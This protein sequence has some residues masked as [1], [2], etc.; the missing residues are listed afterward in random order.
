MFFR[1]SAP[2]P[3]T[4]SKRALWLLPRWAMR[5][6]GA[7]LVWAITFDPGAAKALEKVS[8]QLKWLHQFQFAGYYVAL[9]QGYYRDAGLD[10][11]IRQGGPFIDAMVDVGS[12]KADFGVCASGVVLPQAAKNKV[13]VL[14]VIFQHSAANILVPSR[15]RINAL[16]EL[17]GHRLMDASGSEDLAAMLKQQG[18]DYAAL[19][20]VQHTGNPLDLLDGKADAMVS[21]VTNEPFIFEQHGVPFRSFTPRTFGF[22]FYG[23]NLCTSEALLHRSPAMVQSFLAASL[24]GWEQALADKQGTVELI[25]RDYPTIKSREA[26]MFEAVRTEALIQPGLIKLGSQTVERWNA[27]ARIYQS[28][29]MLPKGRLPDPPFHQPFEDKLRGWLKAIVPAAVLLLVVIVAVAIYRRLGKRAS[30]QL[31]LSMVMAGLFVSLSIPILIFI[32]GFNHQ[33]NS[34]AIIALLQEH[35]GKSRAATIESIENLMRGVGGVLGLLAESAAAQ[36]SFFR[37]KESNEAL[38]RVL[39]S[40]T[41]I[42]AAY[43]SFEDGYHRIVTR[44]DEDRKRSDRQIPGEANWHSTYVDAFSA[45]DVRQRHRTFYDTWPHA[46]AQSS[47]PIAFDFRTL[48][49]YAAARESRALYV[50]PPFINPDTG[51]PIIAARYPIYRGDNEF[52][53]CASVN[54]TFAVLSRY[55]SKQRPSQNS[56]TIIADPNDG[57]VVS[58]SESERLTSLKA[59]SLQIVTLANIEN[60][61]VREAYRIHVETNNDDF[62][63]NSPLDGREISASFARFPES[64][65][66]PWQ[67]VILTPTND[68]VGQLRQTNQKIIVTIVVLTVIELALIFVLARRLT[69]PLERVTRE[70]E[71]IEDL[72]FEKREN[73]SSKIKEIARLQAAATL[74]RSSLQSFSSFAPVE[75]VKGL[76][77]SGIP[78]Q[79]GVERRCLTIF[80]SDVESFSTLAEHSDSDSL[81]DQMSAYF[82]IISRAIGEEE[83]TVD[84]FIGDGVMAF[85]GAP[86]ALPNPALSACHGALRCR[87]RLEGLNANWL[88]QG[89]PP[90]RTRIGLNTGDV[91]VGNVG[92]AERFSYTAMGDHVNVAA[93]LEGMNK[94]FGTGICVSASVVSA[95]GDAILVRPLRRVAVKGREQRFMIYE[96][97]G[98]RGSDDPELRE[99]DG[100]AELSQ[101]TGEASALFEAG[102]F[103]EASVIYEEVLVRYPGDPVARTMLANATD[104][105]EQLNAGGATVSA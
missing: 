70:L 18:V 53:G 89:R 28:L 75:V 76:V 79:L 54:I 101:L 17:T 105:Q 60:R 7:L 44:A 65:G 5:T 9:E 6:S 90:F 16:S 77:K 95:A 31:R 46:I 43:V 49:G 8:L 68:F 4:G 61:D 96:L 12:G 81:L 80:F 88:A 94:Q 83:G 55:L 93:R 73:P 50:T 66:S 19:P 56:V 13:S 27:I 14:G 11:E 45:G 33:K 41:Q 82:E 92:S 62:V 52:L 103:K 2:R 23:D 39:I 99:E 38:Y 58:S 30:R 36:P 104:E 26:L 86:V 3:F 63:F 87:R 57:K 84:K 98:I 37:T 1:R 24:K 40:S 100:A 22:D 25:L 29:G 10:V 78:L 51:N 64:F 20:R 42:D 47:T 71:A 102:R 91:L 32:L 69:R 15:T 72:S 34:E 21:Y 48:Q 35:I 97:L 74:L 67:S 85:W 59:G